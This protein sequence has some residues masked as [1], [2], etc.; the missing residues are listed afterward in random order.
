MQSSECGRMSES[1]ELTMA[2]IE[3]AMTQIEIDE[4]GVYQWIN[5]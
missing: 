1:A 5:N 3:Y 4:N 2:D